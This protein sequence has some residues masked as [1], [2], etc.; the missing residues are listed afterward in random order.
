MF[1][2]E[3]QKYIIKHLICQEKCVASISR[4]EFD[5]LC[6]IFFILNDRYRRLSRNKNDVAK[7]ILITS[8]FC[9]VQSIWQCVYANDERVSDDATRILISTCNEDNWDSHLQ[10]VCF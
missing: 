1:E 7:S 3:C 8:N 9:M 10:S 6:Q 2:D 4:N 5:C